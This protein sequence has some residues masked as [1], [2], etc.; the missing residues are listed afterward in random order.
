[1]CT[2][3]AHDHAVATAWSS[4]LNSRPWP[5]MDL[6]I[7]ECPHCMSTLAREVSF[8]DEEPTATAEYEPIGWP[9]D[10]QRERNT[11]PLARLRGVSDIVIRID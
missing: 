6:E 11:N 2:Q 9:A 8:S 7:A 3:A 1:M 10:R 5:G 4:L